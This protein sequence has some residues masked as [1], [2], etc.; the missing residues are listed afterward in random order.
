MPFCSFVP[1][2]RPMQIP[3]MQGLGLEKKLT[4]GRG[5]TAETLEH[6]AK[7]GRLA[8]VNAV[9]RKM[10]TRHAV[11]PENISPRQL[12]ADGVLTAVGRGR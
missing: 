3:Y 1:A 4:E 2:P 5:F 9:E 7:R 10:Q 6:I 12:D 11:G 8:A